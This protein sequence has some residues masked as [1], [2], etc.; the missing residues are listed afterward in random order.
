LWYGRQF[1]SRQCLFSPLGISHFWHT[2]GFTGVTRLPPQ[3]TQRLTF[4][5]GN[6]HAPTAG[7]G[8]LTG[9]P[10]PAP[11]GLGLG[12][13]NPTR[14]DLPS[15]TLDVRRIG[16]SPI[17]RYSCLHSHFRPLQ[18]TLPVDLLRWRNA[19]LPLTLACQSPASVVYLSPV[20]LSVQLR[21]TSELLRTL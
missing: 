3:S 7:T 14:T 1:S 19:P 15:E 13:T 16:F 11:F 2:P 20:T 21:L 8:I 6:T 18:S 17:F 9:C 5:K 10:S 4:P 12:P